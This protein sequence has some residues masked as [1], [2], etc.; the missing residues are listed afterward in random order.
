MF[1]LKLKKWFAVMS[2]PLARQKRRFALMS[3]P[4]SG[5]TRRFAL[6]SEPSAGQ[7][8]RFALIS[9]PLAGQIQRFA[10]MS[11]PL[12]GQTRRFAVCSVSVLVQ[13]RFGFCSINGWAIKMNAIGFIIWLHIMRFQWKESSSVYLLRSCLS[14]LWERQPPTITMVVVV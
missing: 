2:E 6:M 11:E 3:E 9:E 13:I 8:R 4:L 7:T 10:L 12:A 14:S 1:E 5:Q